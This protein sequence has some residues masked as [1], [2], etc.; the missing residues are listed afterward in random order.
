MAGHVLP[1]IKDTRVI[2]TPPVAETP[3]IA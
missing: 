1:G 2:R 3:C